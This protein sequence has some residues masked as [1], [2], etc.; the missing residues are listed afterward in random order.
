MS[1][2]LLETRPNEAALRSLEPASGSGSDGMT[3]PCDLAAPRFFFFFLPFLPL[4]EP[5]LDV[6]V[7][8]SASVATICGSYRGVVGYLVFERPLVLLFAKN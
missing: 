5:W 6:S 2:P 4:L 3:L 7:F 8:G 1:F